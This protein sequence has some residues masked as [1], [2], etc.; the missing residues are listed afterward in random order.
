LAVGSG[1]A[2]VVFDDVFASLLCEER[3][4]LGHF[5]HEVFGIFAEA[6]ESGLLGRFLVG[7][8]EPGS[9]SHPDLDEHGEGFDEEVAV[10]LTTFLVALDPVQLPE[11]RVIV[12]GVVEV[13]PKSRVID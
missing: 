13:A 6:L 8:S 1:D 4:A 11:N 10:A 7:I 5:L 3:P 9:V 2:A 12:V